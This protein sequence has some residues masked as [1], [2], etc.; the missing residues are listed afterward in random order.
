MYT[1]YLSIDSSYVKAVLS[2]VCEIFVISFKNGVLLGWLE[3][4]NCTKKNYLPYLINFGVIL[5]RT[6][7]AT[8]L[9]LH[10][11]T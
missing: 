8:F 1:A 5:Q 6:Y 7:V 4:R 10:I 2:L 11:W 9:S 3:S